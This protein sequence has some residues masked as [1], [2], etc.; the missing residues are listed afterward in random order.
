MSTFNN[1]ILIG[2]AASAILA[3]ASPLALT[4]IAPVAYADDSA[5]SGDN[6]NSGDSVGNPGQSDSADTGRDTGDTKGHDKGDTKGE[7][8]GKGHSDGHRS[9]LWQPLKLRGAGAPRDLTIASITKA[10]DQS[11]FGQRPIGAEDGEMRPMGM[12]ARPRA[13]SKSS[14]L[15]H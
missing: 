2:V 14:A 8:E 10:V 15:A 3:V 12:S 13:L 9:R 11:Q 5:S 6:G 4:S 7:G 1:R